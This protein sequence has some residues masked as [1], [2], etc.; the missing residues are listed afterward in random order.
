MNRT[1]TGARLRDEGVADVLAADGAVHRDY[2]PEIEAAIDVLVASRRSFQAD[3][4][5]ALLSEDCRR[6]AAPNL[7]PAVFRCYAQAEVITHIGFTTS[8]RAARHAGV[9]RQWINALAVADGVA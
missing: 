2:R 5:H 4:V 3:D 1:T 8:T 7:L 6:Y 9:Q